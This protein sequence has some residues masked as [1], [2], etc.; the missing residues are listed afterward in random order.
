MDVKVDSGR[1]MLVVCR[2]PVL[3]QTGGAPLY[4]LP[5]AYTVKSSHIRAA[6]PRHPLLALNLAKTVWY[7]EVVWLKLVCSRS[8]R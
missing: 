8:S 1:G 4:V 5:P 3:V 2:R 6:R 7:V